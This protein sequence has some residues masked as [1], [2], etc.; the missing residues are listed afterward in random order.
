M[1]GRKTNW[2]KHAREGEWRESSVLTKPAAGY[3]KDHE[4]KRNGPQNYFG[5]ASD[6]E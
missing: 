1:A 4:R 6:R 3:R 2:A 5:Q